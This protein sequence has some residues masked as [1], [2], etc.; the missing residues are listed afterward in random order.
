MELKGFRRITLRPG[1]TRTV[2]F[3]VGP[4]QLSYIGPGMRRVVE[5]GTFTLM[6][7]TSSADVQSVTLEVTGD[8]G[9]P[10]R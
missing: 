6:V 4:D 1:E 2:S 10:M 5:P 9:A 3:D 7:G 8:E